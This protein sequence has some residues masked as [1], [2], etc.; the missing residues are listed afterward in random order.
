VKEIIKEKHIIN[1]KKH[2]HDT[3]TKRAHNHK[4]YYIDRY[5]NNIKRQ[6]KIHKHIITKSHIS[7]KMREISFSLFHVKARLIIIINTL[8]TYSVI[9]LSIFR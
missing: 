8:I 1:K 9:I 6:N 5:Y 7:S 4:S 2:L 3:K